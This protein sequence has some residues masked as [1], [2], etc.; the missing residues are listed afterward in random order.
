[1]NLNTLFTA[2]WTV[3]SVRLGTANTHNRLDAHVRQEEAEKTHKRGETAT[4]I[5]VTWDLRVE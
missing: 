4:N 1:M 2:D 5:A 3:P